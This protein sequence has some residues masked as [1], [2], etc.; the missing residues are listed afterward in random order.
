MFFLVN[1]FCATFALFNVLALVSVHNIQIDASLKMYH[2]KLFFF[3]FS[4]KHQY[5]V[6]F[7][8]A[9]VPPVKTY[10]KGYV[11]IGCITSLLNQRSVR[12]ILINAFF[13]WSFCRTRESE[14]REGSKVYRRLDQLSDS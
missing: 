9:H 13:L 8:W 4:A 12:A 1:L 3:Y 5:N 10:F 11:T 2:S 7:I 6:Q 14:R